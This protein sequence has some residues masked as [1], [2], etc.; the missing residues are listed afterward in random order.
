M[1]LVTTVSAAAAVVLTAALAV[2]AAA[3]HNR[4]VAAGSGTSAAAVTHT[5]IDPR[6]QAPP[7]NELRFS[8]VGRG[9]QVYQCAGGAWTFLEPDATLTTGENGDDTVALHTRGPVWISTTD[10]SAVSAAAVSGAS[11]ARPG[12]VR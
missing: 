12:A 6:L 3:L 9:V 2:A 8:L 11:V 7:G 10:G 4:P 5:P 1:K